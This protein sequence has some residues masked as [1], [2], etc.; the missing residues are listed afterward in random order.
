MAEILVPLNLSRGDFEVCS[1]VSHHGKWALSIGPIFVFG[2][3]LQK[4]AEKVRAPD[5]RSDVLFSF[6]DADRNRWA[7][8][9]D[10]TVKR[11]SF[12]R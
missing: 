8:H 10:L 7:G 1:R 4:E 3:A 2:G 12:G 11:R 9:P 5:L 6:E